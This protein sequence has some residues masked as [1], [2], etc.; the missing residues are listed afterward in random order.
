MTLGDIVDISP[1]AYELKRE[2]AV[3]N[4]ED[5][6][7]VLTPRTPTIIA[8]FTRIAKASGSPVS[9]IQDM[10]DL[11]LDNAFVE[12]LPEGI[13]LP[14]SEAIATCRS[15]PPTTWKEE[16]LKLV[17]RDDLSLLLNASQEKRELSKPHSVCMM[18]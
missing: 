11:G 13:G 10:V 16:A 17:G 2:P 6:W 5:Y 7:R 8:L 9:I 4:N 1:R 14:L 3:W 18:F 12:T 15:N